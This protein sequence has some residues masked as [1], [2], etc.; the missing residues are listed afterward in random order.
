M[1]QYIAPLRDETRD[2][3]ICGDCCSFVGAISSDE[4]PRQAH[5][6]GLSLVCGSH[7]IGR[8]RLI[9]GDCRSCAGDISSDETGSSAGTVA[10]LRETS[11]RTRQVHLRGLPLV[12]WRHLIGRDRLICGDCRSFA[13][14][15][16]SDE[17]GSSA[18]TVARLREPSH[19][20]RQAHLRGLPLVCGRHLIGRDRLICG[21]CRSSAGTISSD[22]TLSSVR[23]VA[24]LREPSPRTRHAHLW[25]LSFVCGSH[26]I[27]RDTLICSDCRSFDFLQMQMPENLVQK[28]SPP[29]A[30]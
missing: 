3:L 18:G 25:G 22:E 8:D 20:T 11:H 10:R 29:K 9:C 23:T 13:E 5:L 17:T 27:G 26:L 6:R 12:C 2:R 16:S 14:A 28:N 21:D 24:R 7:L 30:G 1:H 19:W 4:T 15:I